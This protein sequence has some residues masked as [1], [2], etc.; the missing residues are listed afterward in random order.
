MSAA[1]KDPIAIS[2]LALSPTDF[3]LGVI[4]EGS[5]VSTVRI[6][7]PQGNPESRADL[8]SALKQCYAYTLRSLSFPSHTG[9]YM[10][11]GPQVDLEHDTQQSVM[12]ILQSGLP[13]PKSPSVQIT[14]LE[15]LKSVGKVSETDQEREERGWWTLRFQQVLREVQRQDPMLALEVMEKSVATR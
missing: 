4:P 11:H 15:R 7:L 8:L 14:D 3:Q 1:D 6:S 5:A 9:S 13:L 2:L 12:T 10:P